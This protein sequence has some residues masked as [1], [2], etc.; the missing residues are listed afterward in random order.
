M[1]TALAQDIT[2]DEFFSIQNLLNGSSED[3]EIAVSNLDN[4]KFN[5]KR[6]L[7]LLFVKS[8]LLEKRSSFLK[9]G[10]VNIEPNDKI[11]L[12]ENIFDYIKDNSNNKL[13]IDILYIIM[14]T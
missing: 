7:D 3:F 1:I 2:I 13:Y 8:L 6:I 10:T 4:L 9:C 14:N 11:L 12:G 5:D